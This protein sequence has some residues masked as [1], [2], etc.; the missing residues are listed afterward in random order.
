MGIV[1]I[2]IILM[3]IAEMYEKPI[4]EDEDLDI[5]KWNCFFGIFF[6]AIEI[7]F[8]WGRCIC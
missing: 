5:I 6:Y 4:I 8:L 3:T 7:S 1:C 2:F